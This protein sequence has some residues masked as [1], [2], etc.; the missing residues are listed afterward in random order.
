MLRFLV[1][2]FSVYFLIK[3]DNS[4]GFLLFNPFEIKLT[5]S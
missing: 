4:A 2:L 5:P 3:V 1:D